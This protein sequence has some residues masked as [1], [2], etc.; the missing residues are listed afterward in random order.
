MGSAPEE[1]I[2]P[3]PSR[4]PQGGSFETLTSLGASVRSRGT[5]EIYRVPLGEVESLPCLQQ[6]RKSWGQKPHFPRRSHGQEKG[7]HPLLIQL[8]Q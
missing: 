4:P 2:E 6:T 3:A 7:P 8:S 5:Q 1:G